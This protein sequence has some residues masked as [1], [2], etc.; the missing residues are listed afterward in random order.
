MSAEEG[1]RTT[2]K[3]RGILE[4]PKKLRPH[5]SADELYTRVRSRSGYQVLGH[6][7]EFFG[8]CPRC[9]AKRKA[10]RT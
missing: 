5:P 7:L 8:I 9:R 1:L 10:R 4:E 3:R 2:R 6:R